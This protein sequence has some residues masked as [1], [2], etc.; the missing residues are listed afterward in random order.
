MNETNARV[1]EPTTHSTYFHPRAPVE[2][3]M[4]VSVRIQFHNMKAVDHACY[5]R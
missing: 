5:K 4:H 1:E 3:S 2:T